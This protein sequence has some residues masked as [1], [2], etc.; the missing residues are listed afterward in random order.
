MKYNNPRRVV[1]A[2]LLV[3][4]GIIA[5]MA[6]G[7]TLNKNDIN[8]R[9]RSVSSSQ[10]YS[11][12]KV[13]NVLTLIRTQYVDKVDMDTIAEKVVP[14]IIKNLDPHS[15]YI[16][17]KELADV[18]DPLEGQFDGIGITF[19]MMTDTINVL[20]VIQGGPSSK[21]GVLAGDRIIT[22]NDSVVAGRKINQDNVVKMLRG[23]R[24]SEVTVGIM[25]Q[26]HDDLI[27][28][29]I[30]RGIIPIKSIDAAFMLTD[31]I[32]YLKLSHFSR[33]SHKEMLAAIDGL[34]GQ[35]IQ[36]LIFDLRGNSGG[37]LDQ[38]IYI[39]N[40]LLPDDR[41][42]VYTEGRSRKRQEQYTNGKGRIVDLPLVVLVDE[43][44]A[45]ASEIIAGAVQDNDRGTIIGR[46]SFGKGL[47]QEQIP[48]P[49]GSALRLTVAR[50]Y[51]PLG[52]FIQKPYDNGIEAYNREIMQRY[53]HSEMFSADSIQFAD[54]LKFVTPGGK[55]V[56]GGG[57]IMPDIFIPGDTTKVNRYMTEISGR[58]L[59]VRYS[60]DYADKYRAQLNDIKSL[61]ELDEFFKGQPGLVN[62]F[63]RY[64]ADPA[65]SAKAGIT[66]KG[67]V[68]P[69]GSDLKD[70]YQILE[71]YLKAYI[72]RNTR[73]EDNAL[74][75]YLQSVDDVIAAARK[76]F[77]VDIY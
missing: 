36:E 59:I 64:A 31:S 25:R 67:G 42:I 32:G 58:N 11:N 6:V 39:S 19:N 65:N 56:Y 50:Y 62:D 77:E 45:S 60:L 72:G 28:I 66:G 44:S 47:V 33:N 75:W 30:T 7:M 5:G 10:K 4:I 27:P 55:V 41:L 37:L 12:D 1:L 16:P 49:D 2:P 51:T 74:Y 63:V 68:A 18:L 8:S 17:A 29:P 15:A 43:T 46:R 13:S 23:E 26:G 20:N 52:R 35:G 9:V 34:K 53:L 70:S 21:A 71:S 24:G 38:A 69:R 3:A 73:M 22:I 57:G 61:S 48:F 54:S 40:E 14:E 76:Y